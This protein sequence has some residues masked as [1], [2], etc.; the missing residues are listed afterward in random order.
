MKELPRVPGT[1]IL[2]P[3]DCRYRNKYAPFCGCCLPEVMKKLGLDHTD[4]EKN[5]GRK[6]KKQV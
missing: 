3:E 2:C 5:Y 1:R 6:E 4:K